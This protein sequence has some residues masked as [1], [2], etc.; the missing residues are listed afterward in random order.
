MLNRVHP[1]ADVFYEAEMQGMDVGGENHSGSAPQLPGNVR[2][3][4]VIF[5]F[6]GW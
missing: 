2:A 4:A 5:K 6:G 3:A 1:R